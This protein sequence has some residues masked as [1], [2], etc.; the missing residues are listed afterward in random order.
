MNFELNC[1]NFQNKNKTDGFIFM[2]LLLLLY[3][4]EFACNRK[5]KKFTLAEPGNS[6][7]DAGL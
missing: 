3:F 4:T 7:G 1:M 6:H 5:K 2:A